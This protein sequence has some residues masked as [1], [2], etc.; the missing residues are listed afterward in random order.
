[1]SNSIKKME[2]ELM[3]QTKGILIWERIYQVNI[4]T[5][6]V[7]KHKLLIE[8]DQPWHKRYRVIKGFAQKLFRVNKTV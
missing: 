1:M 8:G 6:C 5:S 2:K 4:L 3:V 7:Q